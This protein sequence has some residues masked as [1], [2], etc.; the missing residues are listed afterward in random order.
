MDSTDLK[1]ILHD[2]VDL[3]LPPGRE[4]GENDEWFYFLHIPKT[5]GTSFR[6]TLYDR[7]RAREVYPNNI[8]Y[9]LRQRARFLSFT[10]FAARKGDL[11][12]PSKKLLIGHFRLLPVDPGFRMPPPRIISF[13]RDPVARL[14]STI[15][16]QS[17]PG[18]KFHGLGIDQIMSKY[19]QEEGQ[20]QA[21]FLGYKPRRMNLQEVFE[22]LEKIEALGIVEH[23]EQSIQLINRTFD[24]DLK[25]V[26]SKNR[27][28]SGTKI[29][30]GSIDAEQLSSCC[31][32]DQQVYDYA[33][34]RFRARCAMRSIP[35]VKGVRS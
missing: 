2:A 10:E 15:N 17:Q 4:A 26:Y 25:N 18:R 27:S 34:K 7:F 13:L 16:Y 23:Y 24:W 31:E 11:F 29:S 3:L 32:T 33:L 6:Y 22:N 14:I 28:R 1:Y 30:P 20:M 8:D 9:Y 5:A 21:F 12:P 35:C 19:A